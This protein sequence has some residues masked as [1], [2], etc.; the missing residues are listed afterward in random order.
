MRFGTQYSRGSTENPRGSLL[1]KA[2]ANGRYLVND[3][4]TPFLLIADSPWGLMTG[5]TF[6]ETASYL[7]RCQHQ[8]FNAI[9]VDLIEHFGGPDPPDTTG[10]IAP[11]T[12]TAFQSATNP[13]YFDYLLRVVREAARRQII[14]MLNPAYIGR[15]GTEE[16]WDT[17]LA[18]A[19]QAQA[20][21]WGTFVGNLLENEDNIIWHVY[22]DDNATGTLLSRITQMTNALLAAD[23]RHTLISYHFA[24]GDSSFNGEPTPDLSTFHYV[25]PPDGGYNTEVR[26][27]WQT[28]GT[29]PVLFLEGRYRNDGGSPDA[30]DLRRQ[31]WGSLTY[32]SC[33][34]GYGDAGL[35]PF[36]ADW[37]DT[38]TATE[39]GDHVHVRDFF[40]AR[41][42]WLLVPDFAATSTFVTAGRGSEDSSSFVTAALASDD[43]WGVAYL[44]ASAAT[45]TIDKTEFS[46]TW[47][48]RWFNP[49]TGAYT[50]ISNTETTSG[51]KQFTKPDGNDWVFVGEV[52]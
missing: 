31:A 36:P 18:A 17:E 37:E 10:G 19:S 20:E 28:S 21:S 30:E 23:T 34:T 25:Y 41:R 8:G 9:S 33:S 35:W 6:A 13:A 22:G 50:L 40:A 24:R 32:G 48:S 14:C 45:I 39:R 2:S 16:G 5:A 15:L 43:S 29:R 52:N 3:L 49:R 51:T 44:P 27:G 42:W 47:T 46:G 38:L 12:G 1:L 7:E 26:T 4:G 11:F